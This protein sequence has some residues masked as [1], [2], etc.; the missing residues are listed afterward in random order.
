MEPV[1]V[2]SFC[3]Q[4]MTNLKTIA[5]QSSSGYAPDGKCYSHVADFIDAVGYGGILKGGFNDAIPSEWWSEAR[6]FADFLNQDGKAKSLG[7]QNV[8]S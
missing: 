1:D 3:Q 2:Q 4:D 5:V 7:L 8:Q 6:N